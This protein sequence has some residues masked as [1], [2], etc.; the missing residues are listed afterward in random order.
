SSTEFKSN[1]RPT[2]FSPEVVADICGLKKEIF[3]QIATDFITA[4]TAICYGRLGVSTQKYGML[5]HWLMVLNLEMSKF[6]KT[7]QFIRKCLEMS[8]TT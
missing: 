7:L 4:D 1:N 6:Y 2:H 5:C 3:E 8:N